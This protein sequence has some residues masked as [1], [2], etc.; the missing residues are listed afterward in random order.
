MPAA[1]YELTV[2]QNADWYLN[3]WL[4]N[5]DGSPRNLTGYE[6]FLT[7]R[8]DYQGPVVFAL[9]TTGGTP[10]IV[11]TAGE[12]KIA[13]HMGFTETLD[14]GI[15]RGVYDLLLAY[16]TPTPDVQTRLMEGT[17]TVKP[18]VTR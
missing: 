4:E 6:A 1:Y 14:L 17:L 13:C 12:G 7:C 18:A 8:Q 16:T 11:I 2:E 15:M 3:L 10:K 5:D 9:A